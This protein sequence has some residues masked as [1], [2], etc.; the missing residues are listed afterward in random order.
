MRERIPYGATPYNGQWPGTARAIRISPH[1]LA[2]PI[3]GMDAFQPDVTMPAMLT[4]RIAEVDGLMDYWCKGTNLGVVLRVVNMVAK[5]MIRSEKE[6]ITQA[7]MERCRLGLHCVTSLR[8]TSAHSICT[9]KRNNKVLSGSNIW[10]KYIVT[11]RS[12]VSNVLD[13][14]VL[15]ARVLEQ[16]MHNARRLA[17]ILLAVEAILGVDG[18]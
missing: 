5:T 13:D 2:T 12:K 10:I 18:A 16:G 4:V 1:A 9:H 15:A 11:M 17:R 7:T 8:Y 3:G 6:A 14:R